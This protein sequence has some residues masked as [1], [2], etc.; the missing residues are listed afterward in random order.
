MTE[1]SVK[2]GKAIL[3]AYMNITVDAISMERVGVQVHT[4]MAYKKHGSSICK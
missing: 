2:C 1:R 4:I 3:I